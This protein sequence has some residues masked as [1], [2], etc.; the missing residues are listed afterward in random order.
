[1]HVSLCVCVS[2]CVSVLKRESEERQGGGKK[3]VSANLN[4]YILRVDYEVPLKS[5]DPESERLKA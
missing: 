3:D 5:L 4:N 2:L 1:M